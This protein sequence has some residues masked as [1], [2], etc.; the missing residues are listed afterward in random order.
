MAIQNTVIDQKNSFMFTG[1][2]FT[3]GQSQLGVLRAWIM[4]MLLVQKLNNP[5]GLGV[6]LLLSIPVAYLLAQFDLKISALLFGVLVG[7]PLVFMCLIHPSVGL[8]MMLFTAVL[9]V[10][11]AKFTGAPIGTLLDLLILVSAVGILLRQLRERDWSFI[12]TPL[13]LMIMVWL[14]YNI[15]QILNPGAESKMAWLYTVRSVAIQQI[16]FFIGAYAFKD[17]LK[18]LLFLL[19]FILG[20]CFLGAIYGLKQQFFGF[21]AAEEAWI[22]ADPKR[23]ELYY[24]WN[25]MRIPSYCYD[26]TTFG[27]LMACFAMM[28]IVL[29]VAP[30]QAWQKVLLGIGFICAMWVMGYTG[31]RTAFVLVPIG[32]VFYAAMTLNRN[33]LIASLLFAVLGAGFIMKSSSSGVVYRIQ[34]AFKPKEDDSMNLRLANQKKIQPYIQSHAMGGGLGSCGVWGERFNPDSE[35]SHFPHDSSFVRMGVELGWIG[36][37]LYTLLHYFVLR[38]GLYYYIRCED[39]IIKAIYAGISTWCFMLAVACYAQE[40][41]LQLPMNVMYNI[42]LAILVSLKRF[43]PAYRD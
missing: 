6:I 21:S 41:I 9:V 4:R 34:S 17:N 26:P 30:T 16:V 12:K 7:L 8:G 1:K 29:L 37:I 23:F 18:A 32:A 28:C 20:L 42:F 3:K 31:T 43:D 10:F 39:P 40:A 15:L 19:K 38:T 11:G 27:I 5:F 24:Q 35:L 14:Y 25:M 36:L 13:S 2:M 22:Y 33:V